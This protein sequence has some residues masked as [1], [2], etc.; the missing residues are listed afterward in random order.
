[1][2]HEPLDDRTSIEKLGRLGKI[3]A[4]TPL[5][6]LLDRP[7]RQTNVHFDGTGDMFTSKGKR[8][9]EDFYSED[10]RDHTLTDHPEE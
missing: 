10:S 5:F 8:L 6:P 1:M 3:L 9:M 7:S 2:E 4:W